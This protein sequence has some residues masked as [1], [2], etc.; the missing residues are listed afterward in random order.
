MIIKFHK[1]LYTK[2]AILG[3]ISDYK[4][5]ADFVLTEKTDYFQVEAKNIKEETKNIFEGEFCNYVLGR[6]T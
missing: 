3:A 5:L 1:K 4:A 2:Q 6:N